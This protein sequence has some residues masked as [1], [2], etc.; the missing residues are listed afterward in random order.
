M[1]GKQKNGL[2]DDP[3]SDEERHRQ[4]IAETWNQIDCCGESGA[5]TVGVLEELRLNVA[6]CLDRTSQKCDV[7]KAKSLTAYAL[8]LISGADEF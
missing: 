3:N 5:T 1:F 4:Q 6:E 7:N 2:P 8:L